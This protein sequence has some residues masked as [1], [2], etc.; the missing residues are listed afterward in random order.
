MG[1]GRVSLAVSA[2]GS[3]C[4]VAGGVIGAAIVPSPLT[5]L[6]YRHSSLSRKLGARQLTAIYLNLL[7][8]LRQEGADPGQAIRAGLQVALSEAPLLAQWQRG[9]RCLVPGWKG[10][11]LTALNLS[12]LHYKQGKQHI[13]SILSR[14]FGLSRVSPAAHTHI[15]VY[16]LGWV[17]GRTAIMQT[18]ARE[19]CQALV[20]TRWPATTHTLTNLARA[21]TQNYVAAMQATGEGAAAALEVRSFCVIVWNLRTAVRANT[22]CAHVHTALRRI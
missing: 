15:H 7:F 5:A 18:T 20:S 4:P 16:T 22:M 17:G 12:S 1:A 13:L 8:R 21:H 14:T 19:W 2:A 3:Y 6:V 9:R 11:H 10:G